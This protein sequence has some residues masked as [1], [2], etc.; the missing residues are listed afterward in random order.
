MKAYA[1]GFKDN[2]EQIQ[3]SRAGEVA[4]G[5]ENTDIL[6]S[7]YPTEEG[8]REAADFYTKIDRFDS[9]LETPYEVHEVEITYGALVYTSKF[10][11]EEE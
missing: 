1:V 11:E 5:Y 4:G 3:D 8:A 9:G 10:S 7:I 6:L 2:P